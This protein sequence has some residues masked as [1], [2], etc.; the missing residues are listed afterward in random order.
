[1]IGL[2]S[3]LPHSLLLPVLLKAWESGLHSLDS[4]EDGSWGSG[5]GWLL[6]LPSY[7]RRMMK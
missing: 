2:G 1:M 4:E 7:S 3:V 5:L 6:L